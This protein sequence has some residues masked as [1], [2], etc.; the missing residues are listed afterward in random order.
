MLV[1]IINMIETG[2]ISSKQSKDIF[3]KVIEEEKEPEE[4]VKELGMTQITNEQ[5][6]I[7]IVEEIMDENPSQI[8]AYKKQPRLLDYFIGQMMKKTKGKANPTLASK[9]LKNRLDSIIGKETSMKAKVTDKCIGC[10]S[11]VAITESKIFDF[12][13]D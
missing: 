3:V 13:D 5:E 9:L 10:G 6:L 7:S 12:N 4:L 8:E 2:K 11:C 1:S